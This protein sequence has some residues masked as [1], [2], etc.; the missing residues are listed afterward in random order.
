[1]GKVF[2]I[3]PDEVIERDE[4]PDEI[5]AKKDLADAMDLRNK[6]DQDRADLIASRQE[7][8]KALGLTED[9][10]NA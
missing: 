2:D 9:E 7:K 3:Y 1:M 6:A 5:Q 4:T 10:L 8:L